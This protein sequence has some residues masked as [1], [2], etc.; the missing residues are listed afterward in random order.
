[1][2]FPIHATIVLSVVLMATGYA[3]AAKRIH[4]SHQVHYT[5]GGTQSAPRPSIGNAAT[6]GNNANSMSGS[7]SAPENPNGR[8][9]CC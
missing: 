8:T 2:R 7:N 3:E 9:N 6:D 4:K 5:L 1:M